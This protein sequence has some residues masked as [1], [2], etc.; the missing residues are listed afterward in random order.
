MRIPHRIVVAVAALS[1]IGALPVV[2]ASAKKPVNLAKKGIYVDNDPSHNVNVSVAAGATKVS[3]LSASCPSTA[4]EP[5]TITLKN[6]PITKSGT[7][8]VNGTIK[9]AYFESKPI[10]T[11]LKITGTFH[12]GKV[13]GALTPTGTDGLCDAMKYSAKYYGNPKGG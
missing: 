11:K 6:I 8:K 4:H 9:V 2:A 13:T 5:G 1:L 3:S 10:K 7:F 12:H